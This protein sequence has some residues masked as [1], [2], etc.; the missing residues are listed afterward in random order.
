[1]FF[2]PSFPCVP[3]Y[4]GPSIPLAPRRGKWSRQKQEDGLA[5][6]LQGVDEAGNMPLRAK[7]GSRVRALGFTVGIN[8]RRCFVLRA[9]LDVLPLIPKK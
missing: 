1:V 2:S 5:T 7:D 8:G 4:D 9:K 6:G 3:C